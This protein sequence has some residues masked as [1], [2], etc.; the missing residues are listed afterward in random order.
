MALSSLQE[1][2]NNKPKDQVLEQTQASIDRALTRFKQQGIEPPKEQATHPSFLQRAFS[3]LN[4]ANPAPYAMA[5]I[6][7]QGLGGVFQRQLERA[8]NEGVR[9]QNWHPANP[10]QEKVDTATFSDVLDELGWQADDTPS[11]V[12]RAMVGLGLDIVLDP[13]TWITFGTARAASKLFVPGK[14]ILSLNKTGISRASQLIKDFGEEAGRKKFA[15]E[16]A[17]TGSR[18]LAPTGMKFMGKTIVPQKWLK[19]PV[20]YAD[21]FMEKIPVEGRMYKA[22][23]AYTAKTI[24]PAI[25]YWADLKS[26]PK[27]MRDQARIVEESLARGNKAQISREVQKMATMAKKIPE[28]RT[29]NIPSWFSGYWEV[30]GEN[31]PVKPIDDILAY[32][33]N[34]VEGKLYKQD[35]AK[36][37]RKVFGKKYHVNILGLAGFSEKES[38]T[39]FKVR[40]FMMDMGD[41]G[42]NKEEIT[43]EAFNTFGKELSR[44][45]YKTLDKFKKIVPRINGMSILP[46]ELP[47]YIRHTLTKKGM[48]FLQDNPNVFREIVGSTSGISKSTPGFMKQRKLLGTIEDLNKKLKPAMEKAGIKMG[49]NDGFF[50]TNFFKLMSQQIAGTVTATNSLRYYGE[51]MDRFA[52]TSRNLSVG[53]KAALKSAKSLGLKPSFIRDGVEYVPL[54]LTLFGRNMTAKGYVP[55]EIVSHLHKVHSVITGKGDATNSFL[56]FYD[57]LLGV[58]KGDVTGWFPAFHTRNMIGGMWNNW[59]MGLNNPVRYGQAQKLINYVRQRNAGQQVADEV[60]NLGGREFKFSQ[61]AKELENDQVL[62]Q[63]GIMD[64]MRTIEDKLNFAFNTDKAK[65]L[66]HSLGETPQK[67]MEAVENRIRVPLYLDRLAKGEDFRMAARAVYKS[68]FD[69]APEFVTSFE[70]NVMKRI[71]PFY[72]WTRHNVPYQFMSLAKMPGK[73]NIPNK[74]KNAVESIEGT[75]KVSNDRQYL[76]DWLNDMFTIRIPDIKNSGEAYYLQ[77]D[78]PIE[79][80]NKLSIREDLSMMSP[81]L[82]YPIERIANKNIYFDTPVYDKSLPRQYQL[83]KTIGVLKNLPKPV[84]DFLNIQ[85]LQYKNYYTGKF[86]PAVMMDSRKLYFIRSLWTSRFYSTFYKTLDDKSTASQKLTQLVLGEPV[87]PVDMPEQKWRKTKEYEVMLRD[88]LYHMLRTERMPYSGKEEGFV[89]GSP[90]PSNSIWEKLG[91]K[92]NF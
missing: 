72:T 27:P 89:P 24:H 10:L 53:E 54:N 30:G 25:D 41:E 23:K 60:L 48:K 59:M 57:K 46:E 29:K 88:L 2:N 87:R 50:E 82:K 42:V 61:L 8:W 90:M 35:L 58:W 40:D 43:Q 75:K 14:G 71:I 62:G 45:G 80:I 84:K 9:G 78:L 63:A 77:L 5:S 51:I 49:K 6:E 66:I 91:E 76:P 52:I 83:S 38:K 21:K 4:V 56:K 26:L 86:E 19:A 69:Y 3:L 18:Y 33:D 15:S 85:S 79:D 12:A 70:K 34:V 13:K 1:L 65:G 73:F 7:G 47:P 81:L 11:K 92:T 39:M 68:Q 55:K 31:H 20:K 16:I 44:L 28:L 37:G 67:F 22:I 17:E 64:T 32:V 74:V 36:A